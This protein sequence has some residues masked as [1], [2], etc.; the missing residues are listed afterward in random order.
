M[1]V[2]LQGALWSAAV[3]LVTVLVW[4]W[5]D[6]GS[7]SAQ[8]AA[9]DDAVVSIED[10][11]HAYWKCWRTG[12]GG[13]YG[14]THGAKTLGHS[15]AAVPYMPDVDALRE[16]GLILTAD[17]TGQ[18]R[19]HY[20][21][22]GL[23]SARFYRDP[24][25][26]DGVED[27]V[28]VPPGDSSVFK[29]L[30]DPEDDT[31]TSEYFLKATDRLPRWNPW[32]L[33]ADGRISKLE[34]TWDTHAGAAGEGGLDEVLRAQQEQSADAETA[35]H[36]VYRQ[37]AYQGS[38]SA[39]GGVLDAYAPVHE[40][41]SL[42]S[43]SPGVGYRVETGFQ[44]DRVMVMSGVSYTSSSGSNTT[45]RYEI[46]STPQNV[47][48]EISVTNRNS[49]QHPEVNAAQL[50]VQE[51]VPEL[52]LVGDTEYH[53]DSRSGPPKPGDAVLE[54]GEIRGKAGY[55]VVMT[56]G[57]TPRPACFVAGTTEKHRTSGSSRQYRAYCW[58]VRTGSVA[59]ATG[60]TQTLRVPSP[61]VDGMEH[62][63]TDTAG[64]LG[65]DYA[66]MARV[67]T[68]Y[69]VPV[70]GTS[71]QPGQN[72]AVLD[73][74]TPGERR[75]A[76]DPL[77]ADDGPNDALIVAIDL[78]TDNRRDP[79]TDYSAFDG[80]GDTDYRWKLFGSESVRPR[81][82]L[83]ENGVM[84]QVGYEQSYLVPSF[85]G[86]G[87]DD[88]RKK[89]VILPYLYDHEGGVEQFGLDSVF[90]WP[91]RLDEMNY[92]LFRVPDFTHG[93]Q[94][95]RGHIMNLAYAHSAGVTQSSVSVGIAGLTVNVVRKPMGQA[96]AVPDEV[97]GTSG[98]TDFSFTA[99]HINPFT[100]GK[101]YYPFFDH[102]SYKTAVTGGY[103]T[104]AGA[105][106]YGYASGANGL[107]LSRDMLVKAGVAAPLDRGEGA[108]AY[109][110]NATFRFQIDEGV[111]APAAE[112]GSR[113]DLLNRLGF[114]PS[115]LASDR[116]PD[117]DDIERDPLLS[118]WPNQRIDP[119]DAHLLVVTFYEGRLG[120]RWRLQRI[121][122]VPFTEGV[123]LP[124]Q[125]ETA[126]Q[127]IAE[128]AANAGAAVAGFFSGDAS[129]KIQGLAPDLGSVPR[130]QYRRVMCR[131][132]VPADGVVVPASGW[133]GV[134]DKLGEVTQGIV[135]ALTGVLDKLI[136]W[137]ESVPLGMIEMTARMSAEATCTGAKLM[138]DMG[139]RTSADRQL[140]DGNGD[141]DV[142]ISKVEANSWMG[143]RSCEEVSDDATTL[144]PDCSDT[145]RAV[146][147]PAC[148]GVPSVGFRTWRASSGDT[149]HIT[150]LSTGGRDDIDQPYAARWVPRSGGDY[151]DVQLLSSAYGDRLGIDFDAKGFA[152]AAIGLKESVDTDLGVGAV[153][154][155]FDYDYVDMLYDRDFD[156]W[157]DLGIL[158]APADKADW[159]GKDYTAF[160]ADRTG[161]RYDGYIL[162]VRPAPEAA[163][164][165]KGPPSLE[166]HLKNE[167]TSHK[168]KVDAEGYV[169]LDLSDEEKRF[170]LPLHYLLFGN[171]EFSTNVT[172]RRVKGF[173]IGPVLGQ[174]TGADCFDSHVPILAPAR[175]GPNTIGEPLQQRGFPRLDRTTG[176]EDKDDP[177][178]CRSVDDDL[179][180]LGPTNEV[181]FVGR[182][183]WTYLD[184]HLK[185]VWYLGDGFSYQF[186]LSAYRGMPGVDDAWVEGPRSPWVTVTGG[187]QLA[188]RDPFVQAAGYDRVRDGYFDRSGYS[189]K[190]WDGDGETESAPEYYRMVYERYNCE[191][192]LGPGGALEHLGPGSD[193]A[194]SLSEAYDKWLI[195]L[196][197]TRLE[198]EAGRGVLGA[199]MAPDLSGVYDSTNL[200]GSQ[201]CGNFWN[202]TPPSYT[203]DSPI[204]RGVWHVSWVL[205]LLVLFV[206][207]L[208]DGLSLTY[209]GMLSES[210]GAVS[211][212]TIL[213]RFA[214]ALLLAAASLL[215]CR[216][217]LT[218]A[219]DVTCYVSHATGMTFWGFLGGI[220]L[221]AIVGFLRILVNSHVA[222]PGLSF[223]M[224][225]PIAVV[226]LAFLL[227]MLWYLGKVLLGMVMRILL[228]MILAGL[229]PV[230]MAMY[231]SPST[232][233]W[234]KK[235]VSLFLGAAFQ[236]VV[237]LMVLFC[238]AA[239]GFTLFDWD[240]TLST[241]GAWAN[242]GMIFLDVLLVL[243]TLF[244][245]ARVPD[246]INPGGKGLFSGLGQ[247]LMIAGAAAAVIA[248]AGAG[249][250]GGALAGLGGGAAG[251]AGGG[252]SMLGR[253]G[254]MFSGG[255]G[256]SGTAGV[257]NA[258]G[259][260]GQ[261]AMTNSM[262]NL[263]P[264][265][266]GIG[267]E[268]PLTAGRG[269]GQGEVSG[270]PEAGVGAEGAGPGVGTPP[271][272]SSAG[273]AGGVTPQG[274]SGSA[275]GGDDEPSSAAAD[276]GTPVSG[277]PSAPGD[278]SSASGAAGG[279]Q[280][281]AQPEAK[282]PGFWSRVGRGAHYGA[283]QGQRYARMIQIYGRGNFGAPPDRG[284]SRA[285]RVDVQ[286]FRN[287][288]NNVPPE[289][290]AA[291]QAEVEQRRR[292]GGMG[293]VYMGRRGTPD[294]DGE[295]ETFH[296][297]A[298]SDHQDNG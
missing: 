240:L 212:R 138:N 145:A 137:L 257:V 253:L 173:D 95:D 55:Q 67:T 91:V 284:R 120:G 44:E 140:S 136:A 167:L 106:A 135:G 214:L 231:A 20:D 54:N 51:A 132:L 274:A 217:V 291:M 79:E 158:H 157:S 238:G 80:S 268:T 197:P 3:I 143:E 170:V 205:A 280:V 49:A 198:P 164:Y 194:R 117:A 290:D 65:T 183:D 83:F 262:V 61:A 113:E 115:Y 78:K 40:V 150:Y 101:I 171:R 181:V 226:F 175:V 160:M 264:N 118:A 99:H 129:D 279:E 41:G 102:Q 297:N 204:T 161:S 84:M 30:V 228:L 223:T 209:A 128:G 21:R 93:H 233:H 134:K 225:G 131:I 39:S 187:A 237:V 58:M 32:V 52:M 278:V 19:L 241:P 288:V 254:S 193:Y 243:F 292:E 68:G 35:E 242:I 8:D 69:T 125:V 176:A 87:E 151:E 269:S 15:T 165:Y 255:G 277:A 12:T 221:P 208:W 5:V 182:S 283:A 105:G 286:G 112:G 159:P 110:N 45:T 189:P 43:A 62:P 66:Y 202:G 186:A 56:T 133:E 263:Q 178:V 211:L 285:A 244:F 24:G 27:F 190:D 149:G 267:G 272:T 10:E 265:A 88:K 148:T 109:G 210:R 82:H 16:Q 142:S 77:V 166:D 124:E 153:R 203:W 155:E 108:D 266:S 17:G 139:E 37:G 97:E 249:A 46:S 29:P 188:C 63:I 246:L 295:N 86:G 174:K 60:T 216:V 250:I 298:G 191:D 18:G 168:G 22:S 13:G 177:F 260:P 123:G 206:L 200:L 2:F 218:L 47:T 195:S 152:N 50:T 11:P 146:D 6:G 162:Y 224:I 172:V 256:G 234:T 271:A 81:M 14:F 4:S 196:D 201:V 248:T 273:E 251:G 98:R 7:A 36:L 42:G 71:P 31:K 147:D 192:V 28:P 9:G 289:S 229:S 34:I 144:D 94:R 245:A 287:Y 23:L 213:P 252:G 103:D 163:G 92:Y 239:I 236:Q 179:W 294:N 114:S 207:L 275:A 107:V 215:I 235:W 89:E 25:L 26:R 276:S 1:F 296:G 219:S 64:S 184:G 185:K 73:A 220:V 33:D 76:L 259:T 227:I 116:L 59:S 121:I 119:D 126:R 90:L 127:K 230:A 258:A 293:P 85:F 57:S 96:V 75:D 270:T 232:E 100:D 130:F 74:N 48:N 122:D 156:T 154:L 104:A 199:Q 72:D 53:D 169:R 247:A 281:A 261:Q 282:Q 70:Y 180:A 222:L 111:P 141:V 38:G